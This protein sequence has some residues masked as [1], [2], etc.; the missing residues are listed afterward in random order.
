[1]ELFQEMYEL[2]LLFKISLILPKY[3]YFEMLSYIFYYFGL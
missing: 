2:L 1:M 3:I